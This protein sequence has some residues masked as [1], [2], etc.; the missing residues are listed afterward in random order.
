MAACWPSG[1]RI[2][3]RASL[4]RK[5]CCRP[6]A[7]LL[8]ERPAP[9]SLTPREGVASEGHNMARQLL[10]LKATSL[11]NGGSSAVGLARGRP[12]C[13]LGG[14][15]RPGEAVQAATTG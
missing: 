2:A 14:R 3:S 6:D 4:N 7:T 13:R 15:P 1:P 9:A 12:A 11:T 8:L 10:V 5:A